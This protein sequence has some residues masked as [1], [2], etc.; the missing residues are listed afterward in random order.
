M[1]FSYATD[2]NS[3]FVVPPC[4]DYPL[5]HDESQHEIRNHFAQAFLESGLPIAPA[6]RA[7]SP[8]RVHRAG[9]KLGSR[10]RC[11]QRSPLASEGRFG[12]AAWYAHPATLSAL[13]ACL[14]V[15]ATS[16]LL[17]LGQ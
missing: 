13:T 9:R 12:Q 11:S 6:N 7:P 17:L 14:A 4:G 16:L 3:S 8:P 1:N 2:E 15:R 10:T 5:E